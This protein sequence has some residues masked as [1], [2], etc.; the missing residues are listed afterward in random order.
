M[1][2]TAVEWMSSHPDDYQVF[3]GDATE[4]ASYLAKMKMDRTWGDE[5]VLRAIADAFEVRWRDKP[6]PPRRPAFV[7]TSRPVP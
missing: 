1:R 3:V 7:R 2:L 5:L 4:W 6:E